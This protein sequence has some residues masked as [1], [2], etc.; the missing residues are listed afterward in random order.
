MTIAKQ[1]QCAALFISRTRGN[2]VVMFSRISG[3]ISPCTLGHLESVQLARGLPSM[4]I[5]YNTFLKMIFFL[6]II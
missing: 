6:Q 5:M 3:K 2:N 4:G 1:L